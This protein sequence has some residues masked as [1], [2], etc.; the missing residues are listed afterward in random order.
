MNQNVRQPSPGTFMGNLSYGMLYLIGLFLLVIPPAG[1][2]A[3][4]WTYRAHKNYRRSFLTEAQIAQG[5][6]R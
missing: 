5:I 4:I 1:I 6:H 3:L 2:L